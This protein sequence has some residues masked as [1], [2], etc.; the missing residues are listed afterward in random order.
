M[1]QLGVNTIRSYNVDPTLNHDECASIFNQVGIYMVIDVN[2]PLAGESLDRSNP[3]GTYTASYL[4]HIFSVVEAFKSYPNTLG[5]FAGNEIINDVPTAKDN[6]PYIRA[7]QRDLKN[8]I[9]KHAK[10]TI[11]VG[12]SAADVRDV[13][14]DNWNYLQCD[15]SQDGSVDMSR[16]VRQI[17]N[18]TYYPW[19]LS[20]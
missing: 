17:R 20:C 5:F 14:K 18:R 16:S 2:S 4:Q 11:P 9:A 6:P 15:N 8:Y 1:Q 13:L 7:I 12:Y 19:R 3:S 10:R